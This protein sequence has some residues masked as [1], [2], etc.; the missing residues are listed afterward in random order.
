[1]FSGSN[2]LVLRKKIVIQTCSWWHNVSQVN[3][4]LCVE[5][6]EHMCSICVPKILNQTSLNSIV[7]LHCL[8]AIILYKLQIDTRSASVYLSKFGTVKT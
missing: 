1:M 4:F 2:Y 6:L 5:K 3:A 8:V 7:N